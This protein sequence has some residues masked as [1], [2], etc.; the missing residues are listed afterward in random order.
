MATATK[1]KST[2]ASTEEAHPLA[3]LIPDEEVAASY[4]PRKVGGLPIR[5]AQ[6]EITG[7]K[8]GKY[9]LNILGYAY[10]RSRTD[11]RIFSVALNGPTGSGK[12]HVVRAFAAKKKLPLVT[13]SGS[14]GFDP[15]TLFGRW[16][17]DGSGGAKWEWSEVALAII[18]GAVLYID[19]INFLRGD[20]TAVLHPLLDARR[21]VSVLDLGNQWIPAHPNLFVVTTFNLGAGYEGTKRLNLALQNRFPLKLEWGYEKSVEETLTGSPTLVKFANEIRALS[22]KG[23]ITTPVSTNSLV[24]F[25]ELSLDIGIVFAVENFLQAFP[26]HERPSVRERLE[27]EDLL[28][29]ILNEVRASL[30]DA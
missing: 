14:D 26:P 23:A 21:G 1:S 11:K 25:A 2:A 5:N 22:E 29:K 12:T 20:Q 13:I 27:V 4:I 7:V 6:G 19:E 18:H 9:D 15:L 24:E 30:T 10:E 16:I 17:P 8:G 3:H 28:R